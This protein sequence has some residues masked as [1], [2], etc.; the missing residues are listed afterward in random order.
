MISTTA[1]NS[2][3]S[4][5]PRLLVI[6]L[7]IGF[8]TLAVGVWVLGPIEIISLGII[9]EIV[10]GATISAYFCV[11]AGFA[12]SM[13]KRLVQSKRDVEELSHRDALTG[14]RNR[15][16]LDRFLPSEL[17][18]AYRMNY[19]ISVIFAD[20]DHFKVLNDKFGHAAGDKVLAKFAELASE[21]LR[22]EIDWIARYGGEEFLVVLPG[23]DQNAAATVAERIRSTIADYRFPHKNKMLSISC[24]F[25]I[26]GTI[27]SAAEKVTS[28]HLFQL[29]DKALYRAKQ[30][31]R[32]R[33][34]LSDADASA[35]LAKKPVDEP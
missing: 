4:V 2:L 10:A 23:C 35:D 22:E 19:P 30:G 7:F 29:A 25:G 16:F 13:A 12:Y 34:E 1:A 6:N 8:I 3:V 21:H 9:G 24:S 17:S 28:E 26:A 18:R 31:G 20:L 32:N 11:Y 15:R 27:E 33:V 5:G 14:C